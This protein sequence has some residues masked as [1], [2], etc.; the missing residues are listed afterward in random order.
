MN[1]AKQDVRLAT[2]SACK[3]ARFMAVCM[4]KQIL[5][6]TNDFEV[7][8]RH[9]QV[10]G[11]FI[12]CIGEA[13]YN[14]FAQFGCCSNHMVLGMASDI[15][16]DITVYFGVWASHMLRGCEQYLHSS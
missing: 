16:S 1:K 15:D 6:K 11:V 5:E 12:W 10:L 13:C 9:A 2:N 3:T 14:P 4:D 7:V 8:D